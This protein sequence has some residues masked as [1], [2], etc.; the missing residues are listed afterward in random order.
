MR[1]I[2]QANPIAENFAGE[3]AE[4][5]FYKK[6]TISDDGA[7]QLGEAHCAVSLSALLIEKDGTAFQVFEVYPF[8]QL[9]LA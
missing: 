5:G 9:H 8:R 6:P 7:R 2:L 3:R 4:C 1:G